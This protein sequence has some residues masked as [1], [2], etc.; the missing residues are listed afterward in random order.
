MNNL[1][2]SLTNY[3]DIKYLIEEGRFNNITEIKDYKSPTFLS[4]FILYQNYPNPFNPATTIRWQSPVSSHQTLKIFDVLGN[5]IATLV[6]EFKQAGNY[7]V[8]FSASQKL[9]SGIY[10]YRLITPSSSQTKSMVLIK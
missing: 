5:E 7:S 6:D 3:S 9:S 4:D 2:F 10:F 8:E 1:R